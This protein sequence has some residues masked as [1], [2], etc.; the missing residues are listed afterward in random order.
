MC[1]FLLGMWEKGRING[2]GC[3]KYHNGDEYE[4]DWVDGRMHGYGVY[5]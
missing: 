3:L 2:H 5:K 4:G 1:V